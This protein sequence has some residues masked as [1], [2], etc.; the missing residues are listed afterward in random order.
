MYDFDQIAESLQEELTDLGIEVTTVQYDKH[1]I[2]H[3]KAACSRVGVLQN[4]EWVGVPQFFKD[5]GARLERHL[6]IRF[7]IVKDRNGIIYCFKIKEIK[8]VHQLV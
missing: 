5:M 4:A 8:R 3:F 7:A 2:E 6:L 1:M